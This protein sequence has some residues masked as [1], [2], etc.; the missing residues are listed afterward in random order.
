MTIDAANDDAKRDDNAKL[1]G[2]DLSKCNPAGYTLLT[3]AVECGHIEIVKFLL[4]HEADP[5]SYDGRGYNA[6]L[7]A[8]EQQNKTMCEMLLS[9]D[10]DLIDSTTRSGE[11]AEDLMKK[12]TFSNWLVTKL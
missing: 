6:F 1:N 2:Y 4:D 5:S 12:H 7:T 10:P 3:F 9:Y 8:V 11:N